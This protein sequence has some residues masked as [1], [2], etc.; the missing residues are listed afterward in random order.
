[1]EQMTVTA[2]TLEEQC[3]QISDHAAQLASQ[4]QI[5]DEKQLGVDRVVEKAT[6]SIRLEKVRR[7]RDCPYTSIK[8]SLVE[9]PT[10][11]ITAQTK[12]QVNYI[13]T[14]YYRQKTTR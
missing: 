12:R 14:N 8:I 5:L 4:A 10:R 7:N 9:S 2:R 13:W 1:M 3:R 11:C 6:S